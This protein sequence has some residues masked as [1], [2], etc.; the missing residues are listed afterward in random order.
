MANNLFANPMVITGSLATSYKAQMA[1]AGEIGSL[2]TLR[3]EKVYWENPGTIGDTI[4]IGD[5]ISGLTLL[6]LRCEV[7]NQSQLIDWTSNPK[8]WQD[9]EINS[10]PSGTLYIYTR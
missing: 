2:F 4:T 6:A 3:I 10:F 1:G 7:A 8:L 9:F 5:P